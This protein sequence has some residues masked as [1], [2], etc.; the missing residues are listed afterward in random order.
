MG[1]A[2]TAQDSVAFI[3]ITVT[4]EIFIDPKKKLK[5]HLYIRFRYKKL[6]LKTMKITNLE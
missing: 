1:D 4:Q 2:G 5:M 6:K 3:S